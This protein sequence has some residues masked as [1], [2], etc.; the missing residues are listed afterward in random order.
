MPF[1]PFLPEYVIPKD[2]AV[3]VVPK[4]IQE[5]IY[6]ACKEIGFRALMFGK[7]E[8]EIIANHVRNYLAHKFQVHFNHKNP[9]T[10][11]VVQELWKDIFPGAKK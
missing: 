5:A 11:A 1:N 8:S 6:F 4:S 9:E 2:D 7:L 3:M 10:A